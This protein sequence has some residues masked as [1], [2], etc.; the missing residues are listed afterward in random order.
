MEVPKEMKETLLQ[1]KTREEIDRTTEEIYQHLANQL[2][3]TFADKWNA[4]RYLSMLGNPRTHVRNLVGNAVF[5]PAVKMKNLI[6][7]GLEGKS[8]VLKP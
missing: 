3:V 6:A 8:S 1:S 4:W 5:L 7:T 2:P